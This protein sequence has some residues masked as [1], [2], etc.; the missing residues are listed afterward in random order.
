MKKILLALAVL[1][2]AACGTTDSLDTKTETAKESKYSTSNRQV[3]ATAMIDP[4][5]EIEEFYFVCLNDKLKPKGDTVY[6]TPDPQKKHTYRFPKTDLKTDIAL[7]EV[8]AK[9]KKHPSRSTPSPI[10]DGATMSE[11]PSSAPCSSRESRN[12]T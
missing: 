12:F 6:G 3:N 5:L 11:S 2:L 1:I 9:G 10:W 8:V 4:D 7:F